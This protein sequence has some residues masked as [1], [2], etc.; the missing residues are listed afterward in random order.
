MI[1]KRGTALFCALI[2][3]ITLLGGCASKDSSGETATETAPPATSAPAS[4][5][6]KEAKPMVRVGAL[7]G[8]TGLGLVELMEKNEQKSASNIY[9]FTIAGAP[10]EISGKMI[11]G[12]LDI[13][14]VPTNLAA[15][16]Y[17]KTEGKIRIAAV[18]TLGVL[19]LLQR[20]GADDVES[21]AD[22]AGKTIHST[23]QAAT[24]E[25]VLNYLLAENGVTDAEVIFKAEHAELAALMVA[26]EVDYA[27]LPQPFVTTVTTKDDSVKT[28]LDITQEWDKTTGGKQ[29][30]MGC[31]VVRT[32]FVEKNHGAL[33][34]F[35][36][37]LEDSAAYVNENVD[38]AA[39]LSG[40][41]GVVAEEV[42]QKA[43]PSCNIVS[44]TGAEM[45]TSVAAY[46]EVLFA[47]DPKSV[48][49]ALP[50]DAFYYIP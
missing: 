41:F 30:T 6:A 23:G 3:G 18:N 45:K 17:N 16:L 22:L 44:L 48:G 36:A 31:V 49:G 34:N 28:A 46:L 40:K 25:Y 21:A 8:P 43:I 5:Q 42:A 19:Y 37:E 33:D 47:A 9:D 10:D 24:Q 15:A 29:L 1:L 20:A 32:E 35:L 39:A 38:D 11:N 13:A 4:M 12:E 27:L 7:Q 50:D 14:C 2:M 26:G